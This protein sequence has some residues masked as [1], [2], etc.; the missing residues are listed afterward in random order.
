VRD[1]FLTC[2]A[3]TSR[4]VCGVP[5]RD[6]SAPV[7]NCLRRRHKRIKTMFAICTL[8]HFKVPERWS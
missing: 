6:R 3:V 5:M 8:F 1:K 2:R 4:S 7:V